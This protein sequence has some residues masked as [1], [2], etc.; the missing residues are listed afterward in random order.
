MSDQ[1]AYCQTCH[2]IW[3]EM[4]T[5]ICFKDYLAFS[6]KKVIL[7]YYFTLIL[8]NIVVSLFRCAKNLE[9]II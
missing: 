6:L 2:L 5:Y 4:N 3:N 8:N 9:N 1:S 7:I